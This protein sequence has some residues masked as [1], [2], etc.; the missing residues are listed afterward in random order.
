MWKGNSH[1]LE[2]VREDRHDL[3]GKPMIA[4]AFSCRQVF[5]EALVWDRQNPL[6]MF[7]QVY[8]HGSQCRQFGQFSKDSLMSTVTGVRYDDLGSVKLS[9]NGMSRNNTDYDGRKMLSSWLR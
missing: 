2:E 8:T 5:L 4:T 1:D 6:L 9:M 3:D 7:G